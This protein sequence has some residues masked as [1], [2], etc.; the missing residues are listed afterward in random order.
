M[1]KHQGKFVGKLLL[2]FPK[3]NTMPS[4]SYPAKALF[5]VNL[6]KSHCMGR[7]TKTKTCFFFKKRKQPFSASASASASGNV[8]LKMLKPK[9]AFFYPAYILTGDT[10][11][12][13]LGLSIYLTI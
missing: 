6:T 8:V 13:I 3:A 12:K 1:K 11:L 7:Q 4:K 5:P 10:K 9:A 2:L